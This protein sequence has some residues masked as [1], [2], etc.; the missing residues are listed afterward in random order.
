KM[1]LESHKAKNTA[2]RKNNTYD[3]FL[4]IFMFTLITN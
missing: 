1:K 2:N 4:K 3:D